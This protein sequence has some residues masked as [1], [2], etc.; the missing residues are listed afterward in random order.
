MVGTARKKE[1][2]AAAWRVNPCCIPPMIEAADLLVPGIIA[3][4][5]QKPMVMAFFMV[6]SSSRSTVGL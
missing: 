5:C 6:M 4:H 3:K 1:N 2:S